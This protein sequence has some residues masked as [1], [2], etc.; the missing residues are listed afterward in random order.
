MSAYDYVIVG[1]GSAGSTLANRLSE[2]PEATIFIIEVGDD[3]VP[4]NVDIPYRWGELNNSDIDWAYQTTPQ[5][6]LGNRK[7]YQ[8]A[9]K[10]IGGSTNLYHMIHIRGAAL[11]YDNWAH[12]GCLGWS[13]ND[14]LPY[15]QK[16]EHQEDNTNPS[17]GKSGPINVINPPDYTPNPI[18]QA[19]IDGCLE[20][21]YGHTQDFNAHLEGAGWHHLDI[22]DGKRHGARSAYLE[23]ALKRANVTLSPR[24]QATRLLFENKRCVGVEYLQD[25][26]I[27]QVRANQ[28]VILSAGGMQSPKLLMLSGIGQAEQLK[29]F[30][31][32]VVVDLPGVG[33]NFHDHALLI[34][35]VSSYSPNKTVPD[36]LLNIS[37]CALFYKTDPGWPLPDIEIG[38]VHAFWGDPG[39]L[40]MLPGL[41]RPLSKGW[42]R[43]ASNNPLDNPLNNP[44]YLAERSDF[45][46]MIHG[47]KVAREIAHSQAFSQWI[48][49]EDDPGPDVKTDEEIGEFIRQNLWSYFHY[50]G[51]CK[52][53]IDSMAV[54]DPHLRVYGVEG[55]RVVDCSI[56]PDVPSGNCQTCIVMIGEKAADLIKE[57]T[58]GAA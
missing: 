46:R 50:A 33:E 57:D 4:E 12:N 18:S 28:E 13:W 14:V 1:S 36:P 8:A 27:K 53:G 41:V 11:D 51:G 49:G 48:D 40:T 20:L 7:L 26:E 44:N 39:R 43:L 56:I 21:G 17:A 58:V 9:G 47:F 10:L 54:V 30:D 52:M 45:E 22:K 5:A 25:G 24:S 31:I 34:A 32:P 16:L 29:K 23:P 37:E 15:F 38:M 19:F 35:P 6:A 3:K 42:L 55:L 2:I